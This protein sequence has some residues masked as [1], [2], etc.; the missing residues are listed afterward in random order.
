MSAQISHDQLVG[1]LEM[2]HERV[3]RLEQTVRDQGAI[4]QRLHER[5]QELQMQLRET[6]AAGTPAMAFA[7]DD[8]ATRL[9]AVEAQMDS[10]S[11]LVTTFQNMS[12]DPA[13]VSIP[14]L[15]S[16]MTDLRKEDQW[17]RENIEW[18]LREVDYWKG[19]WY[20]IYACNKHSIERWIEKT[21]AANGVGG[22]EGGAASA[23]ST[24]PAPNTSGQCGNGGARD[25]LDD[26]TS[27]T[28]RHLSLASGASAAFTDAGMDE[29]PYIGGGGR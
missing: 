7:G 1:A 18:L 28:K 15:F 25:D 4:N 29:E 6:P 20:W 9:S 21:N 26:E 2:L 17:A 5:V 13:K 24:A 19:T 22:A 27:G 16:E 3:G 12:E 11:H 8:V 23:S 14:A 10:F